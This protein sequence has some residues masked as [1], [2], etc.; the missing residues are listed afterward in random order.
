MDFS[1]ACEPRVVAASSRPE[2]RTVASASPSDPTRSGQRFRRADR[3]LRS[4][5]FERV[6]KEGARVT[7]ASFAVFALPNTLGRSRLGLTVT[8][9]FGN[10]VLRN[11]HKRIVR[12]IFRKN[13]VAFD[14]AR[15]YVIN[16]RSSAAGRPY[17]LLESELTCTVAKIKPRAGS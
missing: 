14:D 9:K 17:R 10:A 13:R 12:E 8:R 16:I 7:S 3:I 11:R 1:S 5:D 4:T 2:G 15:D 6:Y